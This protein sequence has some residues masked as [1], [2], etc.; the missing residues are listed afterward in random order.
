MNSVISDFKDLR[1][2]LGEDVNNEMLSKSGYLVGLVAI[3]ASPLGSKRC[4]ILR[5]N[6]TSLSSAK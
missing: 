6:L 5:M 3:Q 4:L 1:L 2:A